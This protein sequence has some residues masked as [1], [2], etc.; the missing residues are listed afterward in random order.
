M[1]TGLQRENVDIQYVNVGTPQQ[2]LPPLEEFL[3][4]CKRYWQRFYHRAHLSPDLFM[5]RALYIA[6][7]IQPTL[8]HLK[9]DAILTT[10]SPLPSAY[11]ETSI[12]IVYWTDAVYASLLGFHPEFR[13]HHPETMWDGHFVTEACLTN[14]SLL[15]FSSQWAARGAIE[16]Y[17]IAKDK[18]RVV[19]F[20]ANLSITHTQDDVKAMI[21][22]R[23]TDCIKL[24]FIAK[25][26]HLKRGD[27][28]LSVA[29][30]LHAAGYPVELTVIG[31][32]PK[33]TMLPPYVKCEGFVSKNSEAGIDK[34]KKAYQDAHFFMMPSSAETFGIVFCEANAFGVPC[35]STY[36]GGIPEV[37]HD[38]INGKTFSMH[39][40]VQQY[41]D[42]IVT[43]FQHPAQ[44][45]ALALSAFNEYQTR[46]NWRVASQQVKKYIA[47]IL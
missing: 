37:I 18:I 35:I 27:V 17:G 23:S 43:L 7:T 40:T 19:P 34:L 3:F 20:G 45:E 46:L 13:W 25:K 22:A 36:I 16:T 8:S 41:C 6:K 42:Y 11:L 10:M 4:Q 14:A 31:C 26:W 15:I 39:A 44:Y 12:P 33:E 1:A 32:V 47:D 2:L 29:K 28:V 5:R 30:A 24:L 38:D 9:T 21:K